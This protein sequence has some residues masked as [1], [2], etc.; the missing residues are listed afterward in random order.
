M[1]MTLKMYVAI[2]PPLG[3]FFFIPKRPSLKNY[4]QTK[5]VIIISE[6]K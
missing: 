3:Y 1:P 6:T 2:Y 5:V 4:L